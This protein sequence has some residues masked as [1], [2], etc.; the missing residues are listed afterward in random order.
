MQVQ[1]VNPFLTAAVE[2]FRLMLDLPLRRGEISLKQDHS[3]M[4]EVSGMIG[5]SGP[6]RG[7]VVVSI[8][9]PTAMRLAQKMLG[10]EIPEWNADV[11]DAV[12]ELTNMI[13]GAAK[14]KLHEQQLSIGLPTVLVG[15]L[16]ALKFPP[17]VPQLIIPFDCEL[18]AV[19]VQVG[20]TES[21]PASDP[22]SK[23][24]PRPTAD[25]E[26]EPL[27]SVAE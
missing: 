23:M 1:Y 9:R 26:K 19:A 13:A 6:C 10:T 18:G 22:A 24:N 14:T 7:M 5:L 21:A 16:D 17:G 25:V 4:Y 20:L 11:L 27:A 8:D 12:G 3:P 15:K 2:V